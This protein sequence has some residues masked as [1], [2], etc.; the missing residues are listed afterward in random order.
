MARRRSGSLVEDVITIAAKL[1]WPVGV[2]LAVVAFLGFGIL[3]DVE[4]VSE[5]RPDQLDK[6]VAPRLVKVVST[7]FQWL[8]PVLLLIGSAAS[9]IKRRRRVKLY[10][11]VVAAGST[12]ALSRM[13]WQDFELLVSDY[14]QRR[15]FKVAEMGGHGS[16]GGVDLVAARGSDEYVIQCKQWKA[17]RVGV[18]PVRELYGVVAQRRAAGGF[19]VTSGS[20]T[21]EAVRF[22]SGISIELIDGAKLASAISRQGQ[23]P[24]R[25]EETSEEVELVPGTAPRCPTCRAEMVLRTARTG[26]QAGSRFWGCARYPKCRGTRSTT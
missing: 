9:A 26:Q 25:A 24:V 20:F 5:V 3:A 22:A 19:V 13:S 21:D 4:P 15:G 7:I 6:I 16:D 23:A 11:E 1:P 10:G 12:S 14:F 18:V 2:A 8:L 17:Y